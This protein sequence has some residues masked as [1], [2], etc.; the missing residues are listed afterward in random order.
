[1]MVPWGHCHNQK[2]ERYYE[3]S[4]GI[5]IL[6]RQT[7]E[8]EL[9]KTDWF[10]TGVDKNTRVALF[11]RNL[12]LNPGELQSAVIVRLIAGN[13]QIFDVPAED[14]RMIPNSEFTQ[15]VIRLPNSLVAGTCTVSIRAHTRVS[16]SGTIR[17][18]P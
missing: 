15:V 12:Q 11:A 10:P 2:Q 9:S 3:G 18:T 5:G 17:I 7:N 1:M 16:N 14:V 13:N 4:H 8:G 6:T